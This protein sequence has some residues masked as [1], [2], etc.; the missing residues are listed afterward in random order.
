MAVTVDV[1][2]CVVIVPVMDEVVLLLTIVVDVPV[3]VDAGMDADADVEVTVRLDGGVRMHVLSALLNVHSRAA[4]Q[5]L[6]V[7]A[8]HTSAT[9]VEAAVAVSVMLESAA[10]TLLLRVG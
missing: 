1:L 6:G 5:C 3:D 9:A 7:S 10:D 4:R 8:S 2:V